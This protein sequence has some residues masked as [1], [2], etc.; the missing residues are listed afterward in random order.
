MGV[1]KDSQGYDHLV[2]QSH[3]LIKPIQGDWSIIKEIIDS[4]FGVEQAPYVYGWLQWAYFSYEERT[5]APGWLFVMMG[6]NDTGKSL[7]IERIIAPLLGS[8]PVKCQNI[9]LNKRNSTPT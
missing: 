7:L 9:S 5:L 2:L 6:L 1:H 4:M 8:Q 3:K